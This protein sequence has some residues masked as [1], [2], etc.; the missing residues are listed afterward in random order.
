MDK[1]IY[2]STCYFTIIPFNDALWKLVF[3]NLRDKLG[4]EQ[5]NLVPTATYYRNF[6]TYYDAYVD[7]G[8]I[9]EVGIEKVSKMIKEILNEKMEEE[10]GNMF[11]Y[12]IREQEDTKCQIWK[13]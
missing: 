3:K 6:D 2:K 9:N 13:H 12:T 5:I 7:D 1:F 10:F 8:L 4:I 11:K